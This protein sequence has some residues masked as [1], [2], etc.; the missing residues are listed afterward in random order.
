MQKARF[1]FLAA[2]AAALFSGCAG[3]VSSSRPVSSESFDS[4]STPAPAPTPS[5]AAQAALNTADGI[6]LLHLIEEAEIADHL[7]DPSG[8]LSGPLTLFSE[9]RMLLA[10][11]PSEGGVDWYLFDL[12]AD[13]LTHLA[14]FPSWNPQ[15]TAAWEEEGKIRVISNGGDLTLDPAGDPVEIMPEGTDW[16]LRVSPVLGDSFS[17]RGGKLIC[18]ETDGTE[19][20]FY[21]F[22]E[23]EALGPIAVSPDGTRLAFG[24]IQYEIMVKK[25]VVADLVTGEMTQTAVEAAAPRLCWIGD[26]P[27][28]IEQREDGELVIRYG[29]EL[30]EAFRWQPPDPMNWMA[31][32][33][34]NGAG[35]AVFTLEYLTEDGSWHREAFLLT[36]SADGISQHPLLTTED[37][38]MGSFSLSQDANQLALV[39][40]NQ[41]RGGAQL[42]VYALDVGIK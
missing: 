21:S 16:S 22:A 26:A 7:G 4:F 38:R 41:E 12:A 40:R 34:P 25:V 6:I 27:C 17:L 37:G 9:S 39:A 32:V 42:L 18:T 11:S 35:Q 14:R 3:D 19:T 29:T 28:L 33:E 5:S 20:A 1:L 15:V 8:S 24:V 13:E 10:F 36:A 31:G 2:L 23:K 30:A